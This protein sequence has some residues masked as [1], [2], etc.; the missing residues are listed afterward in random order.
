MDAEKKTGWTPAGVLVA[1]FLTIAVAWAFRDQASRDR[2][3]AELYAA[4]PTAADS[5]R[6]DSTSVPGLWTAPDV[7]CADLEP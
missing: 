2:V 4:A 1:L 7:R 6:V 5:A 3:C